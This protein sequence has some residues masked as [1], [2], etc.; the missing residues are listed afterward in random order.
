LPKARCRCAESDREK[1]ARS[2]TLEVGDYASR[3]MQDVIRVRT[4]VVIPPFRSN[5]HFVVLQQIRINEHT[6][7][8]CMTKGRNAAVGL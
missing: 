6:K 1:V 2:A 8:G 3:D 7:L 5:P 4:K